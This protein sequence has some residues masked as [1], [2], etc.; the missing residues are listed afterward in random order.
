MRYYGG[1]APELA[2]EIL[3]LLEQ[4]FQSTQTLLDY[5][6]PEPIAVVLYTNEAFLD[7]TRAPNWVNGLNDGRIRVPV[8]GL[9]S[10]TPDLAHVLKHELAHSFI[11]LK[12]RDHAPVWVQE[13]IAQW[14]EGM[15]ERSLGRRSALPV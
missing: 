14:V 11:S 4:D 12:T 5:S 1:A 10:V 7:V 15:R 8:Q 6:P 13:G 3:Q 9:D 2:R